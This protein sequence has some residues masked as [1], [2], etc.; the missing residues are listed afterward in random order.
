MRCFVPRNEYRNVARQILRNPGLKKSMRIMALLQ[1]AL[2]VVI[3]LVGA[4]LL[5]AGS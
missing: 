1:L 5:A 3:F 4:I 2:A